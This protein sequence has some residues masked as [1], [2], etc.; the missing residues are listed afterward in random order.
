MKNLIFICHGNTFR[1]QIAE[2]IFNHNPKEG[3]Q[4]CSYGTLI[5]EEEIQGDNILKIS[6]QMNIVINEMKKNGMDISNNYSKRLFP[7]SL[8]GAEKVIVMSEV[9][10]D[11]DWLSDKEYE[12]WEIP[13]PEIINP[14]ILEEVIVL[15]TKKIEELKDRLS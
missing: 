9:K 7:E 2:A 1:S 13:N 3:W 10:Y 5:N 8:I 6:P 4:A 12:R 15:L 14:K 11:P